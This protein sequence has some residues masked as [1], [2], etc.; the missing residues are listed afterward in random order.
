M[1]SEPPRILFVD[2]EQDVL[3]GIK[4]AL[5]K[6]QSKWRM[7]FASSADE[8]LVLCERRPFQVVVTDLMMPGI[9]GIDLIKQLNQDFPVTNCIMLT[10][11]A[12]LQDAAQVIN[13]TR[14]FRFFS[15]PCE[16]AALID[17][18]SQAIKAATEEFCP[19]TLEMLTDLFELTRSEARLTQALVLGNSLESSAQNIGVTLSSA[20][21]YLKRVFSKTATSRQGELVSKVLIASRQ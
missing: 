15:K 11:T 16:P 13:T 6:M 20:R 4:R 12:D 10:G 5:R 1:S 8:A 7:S 9:N 21:T 19:P 18:I 2:D 17:G 3:D 14:V